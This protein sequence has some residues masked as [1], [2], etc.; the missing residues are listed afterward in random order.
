MLLLARCTVLT[1]VSTSTARVATTTL[2]HRPRLRRALTYSALGLLVTVA[3]VRFRLGLRTVICGPQS[4]TYRAR[5]A[6]GDDKRKGQRATTEDCVVVV[7]DAGD[8]KRKR[9]A[10]LEDCAVGLRD[11]GKSE[12]RQG[13]GTRK[14]QPRVTAEDCAVVVR[15]AG[16]IERRKG[17]DKKKAQRKV[18]F[19]S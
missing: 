14:A 1:R 2:V 19:A 3:R 17:D 10:T 12:R 11:A 15:D 13:N 4:E 9:A 16:K 7:R 18:A 6:R 8:D 5:V